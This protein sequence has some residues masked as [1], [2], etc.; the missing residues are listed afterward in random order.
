MSIEWLP[1]VAFGVILDFL[2]VLYVAWTIDAT[3]AAVNRRLVDIEMWQAVVMPSSNETFARL[4]RLDTEMREHLKRHVM[5]D[6][7]EPP[8]Q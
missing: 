3:R 5:Y 1:I 7:L 6:V 2:A 4:D 8:F